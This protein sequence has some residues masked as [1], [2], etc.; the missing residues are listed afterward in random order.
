[1]VSLRYPPVA[2]SV[3]TLPPVPRLTRLTQSSN[4]SRRNS[5]VTT[6]IQRPLSCTIVH[7][8]DGC[9]LDRDNRNP[10]REEVYHQ[11]ESPSSDESARSANQNEMIYK[12]TSYMNV[13]PNRA[14]FYRDYGTCTT[15]GRGNFSRVFLLNSGQNK[16]AVK[17]IDKERMSGRLDYVYNEVNILAE[18]DHEN[19]CKLF[20]AFESPGYFFLVFEYAPFGD[21]FEFIKQTGIP[22]E[23]N[24]ACLTY[25]ICSAL[26]YIHNKQIVHRDVKPENI[27]IMS[28]SW[29]KLTDFGL[30]CTVLG[31]L[32]RVCG[33]PT[34]VAPEVI[35]EQGYG[36]EV[37]IWSLGVVLHIMLI[38]FAPF[39]APRR[40]QLFK[41][42]R[43]A[44]LGFDFPRWSHISTNAQ[45]TVR[46]MLCP[47]PKRRATATEI[48]ED[49]WIQSFL[50]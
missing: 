45:S 19:I 47:N 37:D 7:S 16:Q 36:R 39:R 49:E 32:Y 13:L 42:I 50:V 41:L 1:M 38:G 46:R 44:Y 2:G 40:S 3:Q 30:A 9:S 20:K 29:V 34:Y 33:T 31:P 4:R 15:L 14:S 27:L 48:L 12:E 43:K 11:E 28:E 22:G 6:T 8:R 35:S 17:E 25:Q 26:E 24:C 10:N 21:L 18:C 5:S 23:A